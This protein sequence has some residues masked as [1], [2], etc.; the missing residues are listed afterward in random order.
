MTGILQEV[1]Q[2]QKPLISQETK[3]NQEQLKKFYEELEKQNS[4]GKNQIKTML[5]E[6]I[7]GLR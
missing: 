1:S 4:W 2:Y 5:L 3:M 6:V 7:A